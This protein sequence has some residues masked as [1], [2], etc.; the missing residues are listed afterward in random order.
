MLVTEQT[1]HDW[2][3][4]AEI[5]RIGDADHRHFHFSI[6]QADDRKVHVLNDGRASSIHLL[7][8]FPYSFIDYKVILSF[9]DITPKIIFMIK[10]FTIVNTS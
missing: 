2:Y 7:Y 6:V 4:V 5:E 3:H 8:K 10:Q 9:F 1:L